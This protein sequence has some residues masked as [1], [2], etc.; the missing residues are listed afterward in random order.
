MNNLH[1]R[2]YVCVCVCFTE[3]SLTHVF[4]DFLRNCLLLAATNLKI[5]TLKNGIV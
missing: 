4:L 5:L 2:V 1:G 3:Y